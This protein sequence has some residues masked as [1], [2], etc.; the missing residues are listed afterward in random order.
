MQCPTC[1]QSLTSVKAGNIQLDVCKEH[2]GGIWFDAGELE[3]FDEARENAPAEILKVVRNSNVVI[4][5]NKKRRC[6]KCSDKQLEQRFFDSAHEIQIDQCLACGGVWLDP[7][8]LLTI[9]NENRGEVERQR[10]IDDFYQR[11]SKD[12]SSPQQKKGIRALVSLL[13]K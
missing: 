7:G 4:D 12:A 11:T 2:C 8:E 6:P 10:V 5:R 1:N 9:R 3:Q 13:F